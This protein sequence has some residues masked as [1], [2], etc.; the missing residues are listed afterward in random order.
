MFS[1]LPTEI[2]HLIARDLSSKDLY[3]LVSSSRRLHTVFQRI[4]Y[5][6]VALRPSESKEQ[7]FNIFLYTVTRKPRLASYV[8]SLEV[9]WW[10][11]I[12]A[13]NE[14]NEEKV[15]F[16]GNLIRKLVYGR[17]GYS[18]EERSIWLE[19]LELDNE[20]A[21]LA[22]LIPQLK[23]LRKLNVTWPYGVYHVLNMLQRAA[24]ESEPMFPHLEEAY[25]AWYDTENAFSSHYMDSFFK[26]PSM[27]KVGCYMLAEYPNGDDD[28]AYVPGSEGSKVPIR[29]MLPPQSSNITDIDLQESNAAEGM[30]EWVQACKA[31]KSFRISHGGGQISFHDFEPRKIYKSLSLHKSTLESVWVEAHDGCGDYDDEWMGSFVNFTALRLICASFGNLV[32]LDE[33][34]LHV[35]KLGNVLPSSLETLYISLDGDQNFNAAIDQLAE[36]AASKRFP[37]LATIHLEY[38]NFKEPENAARY[39][40]LEERCQRASVLCFSHNSKCWT[41]GEEEEMMELLWPHNE[42]HLLGCY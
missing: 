6:N 22:L 7:A 12:S 20:D 3:H 37:K 42:A 23:E 5:T 33:H 21:W 31:L 18:G 26:F 25:A 19:A 2:L 14:S 4:L 17:A 9:G 32:G 15:E 28:D 40:W 36:L 11:T 35:Q 13:S 29:E 24:T 38:W 8:R 41:K 16:D 10:D 39:E 34:G 27:R 1:D 30:R